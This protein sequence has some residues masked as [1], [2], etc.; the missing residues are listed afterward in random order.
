MCS[1]TCA[2]YRQFQLAA[3]AQAKRL[4]CELFVIMN[5][6]PYNRFLIKRTSCFSPM[7][8]DTRFKFLHCRQGISPTLY[9]SRFCLV[10]RK[11][12]LAL[13][14]AITKKPNKPDESFT[15][16]YTYSRL[17]LIEQSSRSHSISSRRSRL[18]H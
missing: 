5:T 15:I 2:T 16:H 9:G 11:R 3:S 1:G 8:P 6:R 13:T 14:R 4:S 17:K 10:I 18:Y 12:Y 7:T